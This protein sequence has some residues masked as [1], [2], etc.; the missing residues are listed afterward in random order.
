MLI[1]MDREYAK[2]K[3]LV[4]QGKLVDIA[5]A[6]YQVVSVEH[7]KHGIDLAGEILAII[8]RES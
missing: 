2:A 6:C 8:G 7:F 4:A 3:L 5:A 1:E